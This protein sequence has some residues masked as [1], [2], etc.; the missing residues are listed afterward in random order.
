MEQVESSEE[1]KAVFCIAEE[2]VDAA[3][4]LALELLIG[5]VACGQPAAACREAGRAVRAT[6]ALERLI[7]ATGI[8]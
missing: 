3:N 7:R 5:S 6:A 1:M 4:L 2:A 8:S